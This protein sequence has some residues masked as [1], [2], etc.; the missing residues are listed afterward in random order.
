MSWVVGDG[1]HQ[2]HPGLCTGPD[3]WLEFIALWGRRGGYMCRIFALRML[4]EKVLTTDEPRTQRL[5]VR[6][7]YV[8]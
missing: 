5:L 7:R 2:Y 3:A 6:L 1:W 8:A 4:T